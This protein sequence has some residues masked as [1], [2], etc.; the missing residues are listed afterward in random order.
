MRNTTR[1]F[2]L[3]STIYARLDFAQFFPLVSPSL[4][5]AIFVIFTFR[6]AHDSALA[7][8]YFTARNAKHK[9]TMIT[10]TFDIKMG[11]APRRS[12]VL[13]V[14]CKRNSKF[15]L[16]VIAPA[17]ILIRALSPE[18]Y[19]GLDIGHDFS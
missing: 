8:V 18:E 4:S 13:R 12:S 5:L 9:P 16:C 7:N 6:V 11:N 15:E 2:P 14:A 1:M 19:R 3:P 17:R 10:R